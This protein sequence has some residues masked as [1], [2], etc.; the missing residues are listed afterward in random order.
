MTEERR[1]RKAESEL[2]LWKWKKQEENFKTTNRRYPPSRHYIYYKGDKMIHANE[3]G[4]DAEY[5]LKSILTPIIDEIILPDEDRVRDAFITK[6]KK[7]I[8][9]EFNE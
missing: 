5:I 8:D 6:A 2:A 7:D 9:K 1:A 4:V 3:D